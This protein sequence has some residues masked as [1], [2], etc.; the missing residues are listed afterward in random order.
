MHVMNILI[1]LNKQNF[2]NHHVIVFNF[3]NNI[4]LVLTGVA[5]LPT[6]LP[7]SLKIFPC[8]HL[9]VVRGVLGEGGGGYAYQITRGPRALMCSQV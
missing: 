3:S 2:I 8:W 4:V 6:V 1:L 7:I 9:V 5:P